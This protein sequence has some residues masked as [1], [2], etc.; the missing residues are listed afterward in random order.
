MKI[1]YEPIVTDLMDRFDYSFDGDVITCTFED[2]TD[3]FDFSDFPNDGICY[4]PEDITTTLE[5]NP[6]IGVT[7]RN[8]VLKVVLLDY[9]SYEEIATKGFPEWEDVDGRN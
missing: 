9:I 8:D 7:K 6:V 1:L 2:T 4:P 5:R 3:A